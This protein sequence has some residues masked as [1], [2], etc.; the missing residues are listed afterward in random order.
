MFLTIL[1]FEPNRAFCKGYRL[2]IVANFADFLKVIIFRILGV[3][4]NGFFFFFFYREKVYCGCRVVF[5]MFL[6]ISMF[7]PN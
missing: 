6:N 4:G 2:C 1:I 5:R 3:F 7:E